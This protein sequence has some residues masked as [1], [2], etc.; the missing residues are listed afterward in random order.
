MSRA[1]GCLRSRGSSVWWMFPTDYSREATA[2]PQL[3]MQPRRARPACLSW[4]IPCSTRPAGCRSD[5]CSC[6]LQ[7]TGCCSHPRLNW[8]SERRTVCWV[9]LCFKS[10]GADRRP[11]FLAPALAAPN[12][13][14]GGW[15]CRRKSAPWTACECGWWPPSWGC[16]LASHR[17]PPHWSTTVTR[18][19]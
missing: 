12:C 1:A 5:F 6:P 14:P 13:G 16:G 19:E 4:W 7:S 3:R 2:W 18:L 11:S 15:L 9:P 17:P 10:A 8:R